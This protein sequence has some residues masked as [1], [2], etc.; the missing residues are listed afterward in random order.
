MVDKVGIL[1]FTSQEVLEHKKRDGKGS[2]GNVCYWETSKPP[3]RFKDKPCA[4]ARIYFAVRGQVKGYFIVDFKYASPLYFYSESWT[5]IEN[6]EILK[7]SQGW[8]YYLHD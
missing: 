6:G 3:K 5:P 8:R 7:P 4:E 1:V 2:E